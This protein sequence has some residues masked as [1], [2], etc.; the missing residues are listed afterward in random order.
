WQQ[1]E[2]N[3]YKF[4]FV[5]IP[6]FVDKSC[7][8]RWSYFV[9][10]LLV[11][12]A[13][14]IY[15]ADAWTIVNLALYANGSTKAKTSATQ[16]DGT[17]TGGT[18]IYDDV[19][20]MPIQ[21][22]RFIFWASILASYVLLVVEIRKSRRIIKLG[23]IALTYTNVMSYRYMSLVSYG[24]FCFFRQI[25]MFQKG[26]DRLAFFVFFTLRSW[27]RF[28]FAESPRQ[29]I[30]GVT[31]VFL[32]IKV[33]DETKPKS[34]EHIIVS[35]FKQFKNQMGTD[36]VKWISFSTVA[37]TFVL[38]VISAITFIAA[39]LIYIPLVLDIDGNVKE[40]CCHKIDKRLETILKV[41]NQK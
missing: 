20:E 36:A 5:D 22:L 30:N 23:D 17:T 24:H 29:I 4:E 6:S 41:N 16:K 13:T 1:E 38:Y 35:F 18:S 3:S 25:T 9:L 31:L 10:F 7:G 39:A 8:A 26:K 27:K 34:N 21:Y 11:L 12:R 32:F 14:L 33:A 28:L 15:I 40:Y 2:I 19:K 37:F